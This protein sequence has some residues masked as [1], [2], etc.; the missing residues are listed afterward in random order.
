MENEDLIVLTADITSAYVANNKVGAESVGKLV[1]DI[2][3]ALASLGQQSAESEALEPVV[4]VRAS[5]K[6][7]HLVCLACGKKMKMLKRHLATEHDMSPAE[8][9]EAYGLSG[10]YP[11]VASDYAETRRELAKK[12]GLGTDP[13]QKRGRK[14]SGK[15]AKAK[16]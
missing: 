11:L 1:T 14:G 12:I 2:H 10:D 16:G 15:K 8:Y 13:N 7:D 9:R 4:S 5:V 3:Q 6:K